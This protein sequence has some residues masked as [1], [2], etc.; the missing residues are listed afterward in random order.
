MAHV[1][2]DF[3]LWIILF[4]LEPSFA[5]TAINFFRTPTSKFASGQRSRE[6]LL[7]SQILNPDSNKFLVQ[8]DG[9][10]LWLDKEFLHTDQDLVMP[11]QKMAINWV[12]V[13]LKD[14]PHLNSRTLLNLPEN[15]KLSLISFHQD[16]AKVSFGAPQGIEGYVF[17]GSVLTRADFAAFVFDESQNWIPVSHREGSSVRLKDGRLMPIGKIRSYAPKADIAF[18][19]QDLPLQGLQRRNLVQILRKES[20]DWNVSLVPG[21]GPVFWQDNSH[22]PAETSSWSTEALL[23]KEIYSVSFHPQDPRIG[24]LSAEGVFLTTDGSSWKKLSLFRNQNLPVLMGPDRTVFVG[25][26]WSR[27]LGENFQPFLKFD[28]LA[29]MIQAHMNRPSPVLKLDSLSFVPPA[30]LRF[31]VDT[32][33]RKIQISGN[34]ATH[35]WVVR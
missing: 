17:A 25:H 22:K 26:Q 6:T 5:D 31:D 32:G 10:R 34:P 27:D 33:T 19:N 14:Q 11:K 2:L 18:I 23:K 1:R 20:S 7:K 4:T 21:H 24:V 9:R 13:E 30:N 35:A 29:K 12:P 8:K 16:W 3:M 15:T 28:L